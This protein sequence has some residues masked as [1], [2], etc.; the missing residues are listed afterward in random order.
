MIVL[1]LYHSPPSLG[2]TMAQAEAL[3]AVTPRSPAG[4]P[5]PA[6][7][8]IFPWSSVAPSR[9]SCQPEN[10]MELSSQTSTIQSLPVPLTLLSPFLFLLP[11]SFSPSS[12]KQHFSP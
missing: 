11:P 8:S 1:L 2:A 9:Y 7:V 3:G 12:F 6:P 10:R 5:D 4:G